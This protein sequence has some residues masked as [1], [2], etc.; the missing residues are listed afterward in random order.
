MQAVGPFLV[1]GRSVL[2]CT[3]VARYRLLIQGQ[4]DL[5]R[6]SGFQALALALALTLILTEIGFQGELEEKT[7]VL[8]ELEQVDLASHPKSH[9]STLPLT[10]TPTLGLFNPTP[11][12]LNLET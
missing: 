10:I 4:V 3:L 2:S 9:L 8:C 1:P 7:C 6:E 12:T 11:L 5:L